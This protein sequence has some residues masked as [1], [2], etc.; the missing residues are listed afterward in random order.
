LTDGQKIQWTLDLIQKLLDAKIGDPER[1]R[2]IKN[3]LE[4]G[5][6]V[7]DEVK[8]YLKEQF[9]ELKNNPPET[10][11]KIDETEISKNL[12]ITEKLLEAEIGNKDRLETIKKNLL[13]KESLSKEDQAYLNEKY[14]QLMT[15]DDSEVKVLER[16]DMVK[17][18]QTAEIG[19][20]EKLE[21]IR[22]IL[23]ERKEL[24]QEDESYLQTKFEQYKKIQASKPPT[25]KTTPEST[26]KTESPT[27]LRPFPDAK[28]CGICR[29][30]VSPVRHMSK[31]VWILLLFIGII[32][33]IIYY[34]VKEKVCPICK[35]HQWEIP[36]DDEI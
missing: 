32:P 27:K 31:G 17:K 10:V 16:L 2:I 36:A 12:I 19:N 9:E 6:K 15:I 30:S 23:E 21:K 22:T 5:N 13:N 7:S 11:V 33:A 24:S 25:R 8:N 34:F 26:Q 4:N 29:K 3:T 28:F 1:L 18:L 20:L 35:H 14:E